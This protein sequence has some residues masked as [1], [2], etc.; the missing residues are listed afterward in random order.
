MFRLT[1]IKP[2]PVG[3]RR[4]R[5][6]RAAAAE[7][8]MAPRSKKLLALEAK[9][10]STKTPGQPASQGHRASP[11]WFPA[12]GANEYR[13]S[14]AMPDRARLTR[15]FFPVRRPTP[16]KSANRKLTRFR[17]LRWV[18]FS[19]RLRPSAIGERLP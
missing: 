12:L 18:V 6:R 7:L 16:E 17:I 9:S 2:G 11:N 5:R 13:L 10:T 19:G 1:W 8:F 14:R 15:Q 4:N 3:L